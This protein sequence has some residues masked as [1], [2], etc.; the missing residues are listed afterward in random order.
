MAISK[1]LKVFYYQGKKYQFD[2]KK[3][4]VISKQYKH[5]KRVSL[6]SIESQI[7]NTINISEEAVRNWR[8]EKNGPSELDMIQKI[9]TVLEITD[10]TILLREI[11]EGKEMILM[12]DRE[13]DSLKRVY[14][15]IVDFLY[16]FASTDGFNLVM[17]DIKNGVRCEF[18]EKMYDE[19][20]D[21]VSNVYRTH[22]KEYFDLGRHEVYNELNEYINNY[23]YDM[24][25]GKI[26]Y[27]DGISIVIPSK[28][29]VDEEY[30]N[31]L[32]ALNRIIERYI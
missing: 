14:D 16:E 19:I 5:R 13:K 22:N 29:T 9:A 6:N 31:A 18:T 3:F 25:D 4:D 24:F 28:L 23:V 1:N 8:Y 26:S 12:T 7:A 32:S 30:A 2:A 21:K 20:E 17:D 11:N 10:W 27:K 15:S